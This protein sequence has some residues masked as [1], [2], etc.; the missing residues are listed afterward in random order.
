MSLIGKLFM[1]FKAVEKCLELPTVHIASRYKDIKA[2]YDNIPTSI[3]FSPSNAKLNP[4]CHLLALLGAHHILHVSRIRVKISYCLNNIHSD[5]DQ[6]CAR[7][8]YL[9]VPVAARSKA[10]VCGRSLAGISGSN[11]AGDMEVGLL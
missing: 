5:N 6:L 8:I 2:S 7:Y 3:T 9:P 10:W 4:I 11:P 1:K